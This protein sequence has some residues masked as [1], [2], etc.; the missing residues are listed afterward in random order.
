PA[1]LNAVA[2][3]ARELR[4]PVHVHSVGVSHPDTWEAAAGEEL[5][6]FL[7]D[8]TIASVSV[9]DE[10]S[11]DYLSATG[12][13]PKNIR[14]ALDPGLLAE[15]T[16]PVGKRPQRQRLRIGLGIMS[17]R[18][19][20]S[21]RSVPSGITDQFWIETARRLVASG[22]DIGLFTT[23]EAGDIRVARRL[24]TQLS[25]ANVVFDESAVTPKDDA[26]LVN[27]IAGFDAIVAQR[28]HASIISYAL[29][30][31]SVGLG[32]EPK[33]RAFYRLSGRVDY[34]MDDRDAR[35]ADISARVVQA[36]RDGL[37]ATLRDQNI[38]ACNDGVRSLANLISKGG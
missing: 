32:W 6:R 22:V 30:I 7:R 34:F 9:R 21:V 37:D 18:V 11:A 15:K 25:E 26:D 27:H 8:P 10:Q 4:V 5:R 23:G 13:P 19:V 20:S 14:L 1:R 38:E 36:A 12:H 29:G 35:P 31:P 2:E 28:L 3:L 17:P 24:A 16:F 33:V